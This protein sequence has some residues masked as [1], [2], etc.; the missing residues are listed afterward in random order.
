MLGL[1]TGLEE[2]FG[3]TRLLNNKT[4]AITMMATK[5]KINPMRLP[6]GERFAGAT[7]VGEPMVSEV[8]RTAANRLVS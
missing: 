2:L 4:N 3:A 6:L 7:A 5:I 8:A 1:A